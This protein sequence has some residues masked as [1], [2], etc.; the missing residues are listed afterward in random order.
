MPVISWAIARTF[1]AF[2]DMS[3]AKG[4]PIQL[5]P[6]FERGGYSARFARAPDD[7]RAAQRLRH[8]CFVQGAGLAARE[9]GLETDEYD[10]QCAHGLIEDVDGQVVCC[11]RVQVLGSGADLSTSYASQYYDLKRLSGFDTAMVE[12]GRF[13]VHPDAKNPDV[14][15]V[16]WGMLAAF[17]DVCGA[18][19][20]FGCASFQGTDPA[21]YGAAFD[22][23]AA[24][25][26]APERAAPAVRAADIV[27]F[28][29]V[30]KP[31]HDHRKALAQVPSLLKTYLAMG[32]WVSDHAVVDAQMNTIH[33]FTGLEIAKI[34]PARA[35]ALRA[36]VK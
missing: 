5:P 30:A 11:F 9:D 31:V 15:R 19:M 27:P 22:L 20:L 18:G 28:A 14:V 12:L 25:H 6:A 24:R 29:Q 33:V 34:P 16:A 21:P 26:L 2:A 7:L 23:L 36:V 4:H 32:G 8:L 17:V 35:A 13:C 1:R 10:A 3:M